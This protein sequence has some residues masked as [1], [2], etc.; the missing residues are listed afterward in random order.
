MRKQFLAKM[1]AMTVPAR[2]AE[3]TIRILRDLQLIDDRFEFGRSGGTIL[4][5]IVRKPSAQE[6]C[7]IEEQCG[8]IKVEQTLLPKAVRKPRDLRE[9]VCHE[10]PKE[11]VSNLPRSF[12]TI[13]EIGV[14]E[15]PGQLDQFARVIGSGI[16]RINSHLRMVLKESSDVSGTYRTRKYEVI[17]GSG[18]TKTVHREF[19]N[20]FR[21]DVATVY[22]NP[23]LSHE[24]M[25]VAKQV[26]EGEHVIDMFAGVGPYSIL[27]AKAQPRSKIY[28]ID[29]NPEAFKYLSQNILLNDVADRIVPILG[30]AREIVAKH[31]RNVA[32]RI[33]MNLPS[34]SKDFVKSALE[35]LDG[36]GGIIHY[37]TF[38][39]RNE[40]IDAVAQTIR[41]IVKEHGS[42]IE[43]ILFA[44]ILKEVAP[45]K[46]QIALDL[47][48]K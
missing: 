48:I 2:T 12:D 35:A 11:L 1:V 39:S 37:Y 31:L 28:A 14:V 25:R 5:P 41:E 24:R 46:V 17:A 44:K 8:S 47:L 26:K 9:A 38:A 10:I 20:R 19:S 6:A 16:L 43:S 42:K 13:G 4:I 45:G 15:L 40:T 3:R 23:R 27:I 18:A 30:D 34:E 22:F 21:L 36:R 33:V 32:N 29:I 7:R